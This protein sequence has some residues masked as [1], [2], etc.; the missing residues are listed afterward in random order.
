VKVGLLAGDI[1]GFSVG[2]RLTGIDGTPKKSGLRLCQTKEPL[3]KLNKTVTQA[4]A[5]GQKPLKNQDSGLKHAGMTMKE[6][7]R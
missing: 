4:E 3:A 6:L 1:G 2:S 7:C 5:E